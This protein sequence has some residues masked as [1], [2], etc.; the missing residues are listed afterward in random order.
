[1]GYW[2]W[3]NGGIRLTWAGYTRQQTEDITGSIPLLLDG[4]VVESEIDLSA[5][6]LMIIS[7]QALQFLEEQYRKDTGVWGRLVTLLGS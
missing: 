5:L 6:P 2:W 1:M 7:E 3:R 4:C